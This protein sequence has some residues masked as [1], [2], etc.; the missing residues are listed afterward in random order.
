MTDIRGGGVRR[1]VSGAAGLYGLGGSGRPR[2]EGTEARGARHKG[3][4]MRS[5]FWT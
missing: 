3:D 2:C 1:A 4:D 5:S